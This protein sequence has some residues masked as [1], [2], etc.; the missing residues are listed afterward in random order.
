MWFIGVCFSICFRISSKGSVTI[1][2]SNWFQ[3]YCSAVICVGFTCLL[4][5][6]IRHPVFVMCMV[7]GLSLLVWSPFPSIVQWVHSPLCSHWTAMVDY[8]NRIIISGG[9]MVLIIFS[10]FWLMPHN[11]YH[12]YLYQLIGL[13]IVG[14][15]P[16]IWWLNNSV[17]GLGIS[18]PYGVD[19]ICSEVIC[20]SDLISKHF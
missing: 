8:W 12:C 5:L 9:I 15:I 20:G 1:C 7:Y 19:L 18:G 13:L 17:A 6:E 4:F 11:V 3:R 16:L 14:M 2:L 10:V